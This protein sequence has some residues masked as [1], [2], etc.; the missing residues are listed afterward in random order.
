MLAA[1]LLGCF[2]NFAMSFNLDSQFIKEILEQPVLHQCD[3]GYV[4]EQTS[5]DRVMNLFRM[6]PE[7]R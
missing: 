5:E 3:I 2:A 6:L 7:N 1:L 4:H